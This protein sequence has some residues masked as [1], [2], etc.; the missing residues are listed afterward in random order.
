MSNNPAEK[1][2]LVATPKG[3]ASSYRSIDLGVTGLIAKATPGK[4]ISIHAHNVNAATRFL[5][6]YNK[7]TAPTEADTPKL[8]IPLPTGNSTFFLGDSGVDF[9]AGISVRATTGLAD[10]DTGAP[11][12]SQTIVNL[13]YA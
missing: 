12:A 3:G 6:I 4:L 11:T 10:N 2:Y 8:T 1:T 13:T 9:T 7:A 5:K